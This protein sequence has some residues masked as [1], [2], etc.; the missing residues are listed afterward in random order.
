M[1]QGDIYLVDLDP[2]CGHEQ[3]GRRPV[4]VVSLASFNRVTGLPVVL[5]ITTKGNFARARGFAVPLGGQGTRT[6]GVIRCDQPRTLDLAA[7]NA[8]KLESVP[9]D[10]LDDVLARLAVIF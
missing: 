3:G 6:Q 5:P 4:L 8:K 1:D 9:Q 7:R 10:I 2:T